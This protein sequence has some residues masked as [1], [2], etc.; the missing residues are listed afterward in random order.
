MQ[1]PQRT[2]NTTITAQGDYQSSVLDPQANGSALK[3]TLSDSI[4][5]GLQFNL[6]SI[7]VTNSL[8]QVRAQRL[9]ALSSLRPNISASL[10]YTNQK[11]DLEA[12]GIS[13]STG[14]SF[15][16]MLPKV[17]GP[18]HYYDG[19]AGPFD[20][21]GPSFVMWNIDN[22]GWQESTDPI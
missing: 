7:N 15:G 11:T 19:G 5:R 3:L 13:A 16:S 14:S 22:F 1:A 6:G 9:A 8:R 2:I 10:N 17:V 4:R 12:I 18:Y 21:A 20:R